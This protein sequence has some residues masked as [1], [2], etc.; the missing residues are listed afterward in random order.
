MAP[1]VL[2][3]SQNSVGDL[4]NSV[5]LIAQLCVKTQ[6]QPDNLELMWKNSTTLGA[7]IKIYTNSKNDYKG[8]RLTTIC[9]INKEDA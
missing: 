9:L 3:N 8:A 4:Q 2:H 7:G 6:K 1:L 5:G